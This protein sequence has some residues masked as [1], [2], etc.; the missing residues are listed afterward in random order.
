MRR[1]ILFSVLGTVLLVASALCVRGSSQHII[2][3]PE[4]YRKWV[5]IK[6]VLIGPQSPFFSTDGGIHHVY[7]NAKA[8]EGFDTGKFPDGAILVYELLDVKETNGLTVEGAR[9]RVDVMVKDE[10]QFSSTKGWGF[11]RFLGDS[12]TDRPLTEERRTQC[13]SCH[14]QVKAHEYVFSEYRK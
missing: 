3:Y 10:Q 5:N 14:E 9:R 4:N 13:F 1:K 7:A 6:T 11:E 2:S 8:M 12:E